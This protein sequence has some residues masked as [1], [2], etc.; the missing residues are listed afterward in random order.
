METKPAWKTT[1]FWVMVATQLIGILTLAGVFTA[2][3]SEALSSGIQAIVGAV[4]T[5][6]SAF[7]YT[8]NRTEIKKAR[9]ALIAASHAANLHTAAA[10]G[11]QSTTALMK[12]SGL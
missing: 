3:E 5:I 7:G 9:G 8:W 1:E 2:K 11:L 10:A 12:Q 6:A 4:I